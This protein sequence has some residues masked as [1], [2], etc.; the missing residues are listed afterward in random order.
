MRRCQGR[1]QEEGRGPRSQG[2][3]VSGVP[4]SGAGLPGGCFWLAPFLALHLVGTEK[5]TRE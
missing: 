2:L 5:I 3:G 4:F 1:A